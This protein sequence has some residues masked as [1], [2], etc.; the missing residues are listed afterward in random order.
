[1]DVL[2]DF[3]P[4]VPRDRI[5]ELGFHPKALQESP[6]WRKTRVFLR[7]RDL[8]GSKRRVMILLFCLG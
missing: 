6:Y 7:F 8:G 3:W 4:R 2:E 1:M 5:A